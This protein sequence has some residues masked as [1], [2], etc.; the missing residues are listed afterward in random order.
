MSENVL[1]DPEKVPVTVAFLHRRE[2]QVTLVEGVQKE[3]WFKGPTDAA[4]VQSLL[5]R[6]G[7]GF[8][9]EHRGRGFLVTAA[10]VAKLL[11]TDF[12]V[13]VL[14]PPDQPATYHVQQLTLQKATPVWVSAPN[15]DVAVLEITTKDP[16]IL[17]VISG[18]FLPS[19]FL[20]PALTAPARNKPITVLGFPQAL[21]TEGHFS[22]L[23]QQT[24]TSSGLLT[25]PL[26]TGRATCFVLQSPSVSGYSGAP[27][28]DFGVYT[29]GQVTTTGEK[30]RCYGLMHGTFSDETGGKLGVVVPSHFIVKTLDSATAGDTGGR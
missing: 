2:P 5:T 11:G 29:F 7:T 12:R 3:V 9:V 30:S 13:T 26:E 19:S 17:A 15:A 28:F 16:G 10:H 4:P 23:S 25:L 21:G 8:F 27:V 24:F 20:E 22:P 18:R 6:C 1:L 14:V